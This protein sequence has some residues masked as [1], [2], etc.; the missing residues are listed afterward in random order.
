MLPTRPRINSTLAQCVEVLLESCVLVFSF[1][2]YSP[3]LT[4][5]SR[6]SQVAS[7]PWFPLLDYP[8]G[9]YLPFLNLQGSGRVMQVNGC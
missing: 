6:A 4:V 7:V 8:W 5:C 2:F 9:I 3:L 1:F